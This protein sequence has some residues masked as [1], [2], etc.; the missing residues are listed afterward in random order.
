[1]RSVIRF[2][3]AFSLVFPLALLAGTAAHVSA[4]ELRVLPPGQAHWILEE[5][6]GD[7][8]YEHIRFMTQ[9]HRPTG[10]AAG[11]WTVAEYYEEKAKEYGLS[12]V[13]LIKQ[14][15]TTPPWNANRAELWIE[16]AR[17][18]RL[19]STLQ[20]PLHLADFSNS[21]SVTAELVAVGA[22]TTGADYEGKAIRGK[23]VLA[24]GPLG[25]VFREAIV[26]RGAAGIVWHPSPYA[27]HSIS[28]PDQ[29][30]WSRV[31][32]DLSR[33]HPGAFA[34]ILSLRQGIAL[35]ERLVREGM[36]SV[37]AEVDAAFDSPVG[38]EPWQVMVEAKILGTEPGLAQDIV[39][40][41]H[42]QEE[43]FSANDDASGTASVLEVAR[44]LNHLITTG[45]IPR[46]R[47]TLRFWWVTEISSQRQYF[48]DN[49][50][51][52]RSMW[53][54]VNNDMVGADQSQDLLRVQNITR[55]PATRFHFFNDVVESVIDYMVATNTAELAQ[56]Q[57]G[58]GDPY[59]RP[60]LSRL[61]SRHRYNAKLVY[62]HN[63]T[64]HMP[65]NEAP[66]GVPGITFTNWPD[67]YI[68]SSDD[69]L[70][71]ID[72]T[73]LGRNAASTALIAY[74]MASAGD[75]S[76][77]PLALETMG[78]GAQRLARNLSLGLSWIA[79]A[80]DRDGAYHLAQ[81]QIAYALER[82][83][84][85][86]RSLGEISPAA[87]ALVPALLSTLNT[88]G[89]Q[90]QGELRSAYTALSGKRQAAAK[91]A[92]TAAERRLESLLPELIAG[93]A[94][95]LDRRNRLGGVAGLHGI[96]SFGILNAVNGK[97]TG[98]DIYRYL[99][100]EAREAGAH[101]Y[102]TIEPEAVLEYLERAAN[103][104]LIRLH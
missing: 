27:E 38:S 30:S 45:R 11:L 89:Q 10:G 12:D 32:A 80:S 37:R 86:V 96:M 101:Y 88:R 49:P 74:T 43:K 3:H 9:F 65:F 16:G 68:H 98:L 42:L 91:A 92:P 53:V 51:A 31:P 56:I 1:M 87:G 97:R 99:A 90:L 15:A 46:P 25:V 40:T 63:N 59:P 5:V 26:E 7:A 6:S 104:E 34:F 77:G 76:A 13:R 102:G 29:I 69:D 100:A 19:A 44:A 23:V 28:Y 20:T 73:Q 75:E 50:N 95:F 83:E 61:G 47:R 94:E 22:G 21:A 8:A 17:P 70:W 14:K 72:R 64:D 41:G 85:A 2:R 93:P 71:N 82:E 35:Q 55:L 62:H 24:Y 103:L 60:H 54:N 84:Q 66:I 67:S 36:L 57:A 81:E 79:A 39:L 48:A 4:Q 18:E 33:R 78:R 52:H 58:S